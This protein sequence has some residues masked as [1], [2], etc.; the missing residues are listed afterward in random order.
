MVKRTKQTE[1]TVQ[2][3]ETVV[4]RGSARTF[5]GC[6]QCASVTAAMLS[7]EAAAALAGI[8]AHDIYRWLECGAIHSFQI[9]E[10]LVFVCLPSLL[11]ARNREAFE[12]N[13]HESN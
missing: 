9:S 12:E 8:P 10:R 1:T 2:L 6:E 4:I 11:E 7:P 5:E 13:Y 3:C